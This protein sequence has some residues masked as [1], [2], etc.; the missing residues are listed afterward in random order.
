MTIK[1]EE[2]RKSVE[3]LFKKTNHDCY[4]YLFSI[5]ILVLYE[6][7]INIFGS[8]N[9]VAYNSVDIWFPISNWFFSGFPGITLILSIALIIS[10]GTRMFIEWN[11]IKTDAEKKKDKKAEADFNK[12]P[13][14]K[15]LD[16][17]FKAKEKKKFDFKW[18]PVFTV[19]IEGL[20]YGLGVF[21]LVWG[22]TEV[23][24]YMAGAP[25]E[26]SLPM[27]R[28]PSMQSYHT[29]VG[30]DIGLAL[31]AGFYD[32][33]IFRFLLFNIIIARVKN[34]VNDEAFVMAVG[35]S[36]TS[37]LKMSKKGTT[38]TQNFSAS[39]LVAVVF[40]I[41]HSLLGADLPTV[42]STLYR[43]FFSLAMSYIF[44]K[45][46]LQVAACTH[47]AYDLLYFFTKNF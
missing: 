5:G 40:A 28:D 20:L 23:F 33:F 43:I 25:V 2:Y 47:V 27:D 46:N 13:Y 17:K 21:I 1:F 19:L 32:E 9:I 3:A 8:P 10:F 38:R 18:A 26:S 36:K 35:K 11:G 12:F 29:N 37:F 31:G 34:Y 30:Q 22:A 24:L 44:L 4:Q 39:L 41:S 45:R 7:L 42:Y 14:N 6:L 15:Q 16:R